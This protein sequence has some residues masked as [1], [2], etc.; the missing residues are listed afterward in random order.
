MASDITLK[1]D[2][3]MGN[4]IR[5]YASLLAKLKDNE[6]AMKQMNQ[7]VKALGRELEETGGKGKR[8][9]GGLSSMFGQVAS[10]LAPGAMLAGGMAL[11]NRALQEAEQNAAGAAARVA[12][13]YQDT[14]RLA[15]AGGSPSGSTAAR[16]LRDELR[17]RYGF[18]PGA[19][20]LLAET[21]T[22]K[23]LDVT[24][25]A[26]AQASAG[27]PGAQM[28]E[29][30]ADFRDSGMAQGVSEEQFVSQVLAASAAAG[31]R[32][33]EILARIAALGP[34]AAPQGIGTAEALALSGAAGFTKDKRAQGAMLK[35]LGALQGGTTIQV[36][37]G[38]G[39]HA[40]RDAVT[41]TFGGQPVL[42]GLAGLQ[43]FAP[44]AYEELLRDAD[45]ATLV[46]QYPQVLTTAAGI[47]AQ[48]AGGRPLRAAEVSSRDPITVAERARQ[49]AVQ[50]RAVSEEQRLAEAEANYQ[51]AL[52]AMEGAN[53]KNGMNAWRR[54]DRRT[55]VQIARRFGGP[56]F[57]E[58]MAW[59]FAGG[60]KPTTELGMDAAVSA[61][62]SIAASA[63]GDVR[64]RSVISGAEL[65]EL[66]RIRESNEAMM[67]E[68]RGSTL[69][70]DQYT[71]ESGPHNFIP[72]RFF[73]VL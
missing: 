34:A 58:Q 11:F 23:K 57:G 65:Q 9:V 49:A 70:P 37:R 45:V 42:Q 60:G 6:Q 35:L 1:F 20:A 3:D 46:R 69:R 72:I 10:L 31:D 62:G 32:P 38:A 64:P 22:R 26:R 18:E 25:F 59:E 61:I 43:A 7:Q 30:L 17:S 27:A 28:M 16:G 19:A 5:E 21:A 4:S 53:E 36:P 67:R 44:G 48:A 63:I 51:A 47:E 33:E 29:M 13:M 2:A 8:S 71:P 40:P 55:R 73:G 12:Q 54:W 24:P 50:S 52:A 39:K 66:R 41:R 15:G 68:Q 14:L 56:E